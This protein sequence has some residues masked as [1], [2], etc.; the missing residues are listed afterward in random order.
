MSTPSDT[1]RTD[2]AQFGTNRIS[3]SFARTLEQE[4]NAALARVKEVEMERDVVASRPMYYHQLRDRVR[5]LEGE[6]AKLNDPVAVHINMLRGTIATPSPETMA[7][8]WGTPPA[9]QYLDRPDKPG[10]W[11]AWSKQNKQWEIELVVYPESWHSAIWL[12][13]TPPPSKEGE[14]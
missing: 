1:P 12:P 2:E 11:W 3:V 7:H 13:V 10:W 4:L 5:E 9:Q 14:G 6:L 8:V